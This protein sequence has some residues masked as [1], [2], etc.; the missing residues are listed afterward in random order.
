MHRRMMVNTVSLE[1]WRRYLTERMRI[2]MLQTLVR[3]PLIS[4]TGG[5]YGE[6]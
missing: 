3:V 1:A 5:G 6:M 4:N 2:L